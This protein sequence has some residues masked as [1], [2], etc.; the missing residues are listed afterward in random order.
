MVGSAVAGPQAALWTWAEALAEELHRT[1]DVRLTVVIPPR[2]A[3]P[4]QRFVAERSGHRARLGPADA[5]ALLRAVL[6]GRRRAG[7]LPVLAA[8]AMLRP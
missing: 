8:A 3:S 6:A 5:G 2:T 4:T 1:P 7:R